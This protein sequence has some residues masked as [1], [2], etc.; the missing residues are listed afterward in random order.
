[1]ENLWKPEKTNITFFS[2]EGIQVILAYNW[3]PFDKPHST[4]LYWGNKDPRQGLWDFKAED[5]GKEKIENYW[6]E[7]LKLSKERKLNFENVYNTLERIF[8]EKSPLR[9]VRD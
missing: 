6:K 4:I 1:M 3:S 2:E 7:V 9:V 5:Y 8:L